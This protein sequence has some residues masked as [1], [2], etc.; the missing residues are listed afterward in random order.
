MQAPV[1]VSGGLEGSLAG[2]RKKV[3]EACGRS[4]YAELVRRNAL[5]NEL[6]RRARAEVRRRLA[7]MPGSQPASF[8]KAHGPWHVFPSLLVR[9]YGVFDAA[10]YLERYPDVRQA[11]IDALRHYMRHGA[12]ERRKPHPLFEP[13][14][15]QAHCP[16]ARTSRNPLLHF[17]DEAP[18]CSPHPL[19]DCGA[20]V[21]ANPNARNQPLVHY[22]RTRQPQGSTGVPGR[23][24]RVNIMDVPVTVVFPETP[25]DLSAPGYPACPVL[26]WKDAEGRKQVLAPPQQQPFFRAVGYDQLRAQ[27]DD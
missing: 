21:D 2:R 10:F 8:A 27:L 18:M 17:L 5:D 7:L 9:R 4:V 26:V 1:N 3:R 6:V 19:F 13:D 23:T 16:E 12:A 22:L 15:Y 14:Y 11:G 24:A 25:P 20:Y